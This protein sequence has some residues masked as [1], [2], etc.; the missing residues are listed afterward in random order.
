MNRASAGPAPSAA[1]A[2]MRRSRER[3]REGEVIVSL[4]LGPDVTADLVELG[5]LP[6][7]AC[8]EKGALAR[9]LANLIERTMAMRV[10][11]TGS[12]GVCFRRL[13]ATVGPMVA[14]S[15][16][17]ERLSSK[18][19]TP[20]EQSSPRRLGPGHVELGKLLGTADGASEIA[21]NTA[22][23]AQPSAEL[24]EPYEIDLIELWVPRLDLFTRAGMWVPEWG[25]RPDQIGCAAP[26]WLLNE[27]SIRPSGLA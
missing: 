6:K 19:G 23:G 25:P 10:T 2:R 14:E 7:T 9:A 5:W 18:R 13:R 16:E 12:E 8:D 27:Y 17:S 20:A 15:S 26:E 4:T 22:P 3:R 11:P 21:E 1:A 24:I